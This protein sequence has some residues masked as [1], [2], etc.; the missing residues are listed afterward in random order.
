MN[1][2]TYFSKNHVLHRIK[3]RFL[4]SLFILCVLS[5]SSYAQSTGIF[6]IDYL[7]SSWDNVT[8]YANTIQDVFDVS[9]LPNLNR[10]EPISVTLTDDYIVENTTPFE[11]IIENDVTYEVDL[12]DHQLQVSAN[13]TIKT[14]GSLRII[15]DNQKTKFVNSTITVLP[16]E[17]DEHNPSTLYIDGIHIESPYGK[18]CLTIKPDNDKNSTSVTLLDGEFFSDFAAITNQ[19]PKDRS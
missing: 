15:G 12:I 1:I 18:S 11:I 13:F 8:T 16:P 4:F 7:N 5:L 9:I 10:D 14:G 19:G 3:W 6:R 17:N 2:A